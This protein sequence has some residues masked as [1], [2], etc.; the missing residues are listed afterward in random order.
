MTWFWNSVCKIFCKLSLGQRKTVRIPWLDADCGSQHTGVCWLE[1]EPLSLISLRGPLSLGPCGI[2]FWARTWEAQCCLVP[3]C[4]CQWKGLGRKQAMCW[5][6]GEGQAQ[7]AVS[8]Q[9][10]PC[11]GKAGNAPVTQLAIIVLNYF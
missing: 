9:G 11:W 3:G 2:Q 4:R 7:G 1:K 10:S 6:W 8:S 5:T